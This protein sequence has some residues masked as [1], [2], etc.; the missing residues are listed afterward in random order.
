M[1]NIFNYP[2]PFTDKTYFFFEHNQPCCDLDVEIDIYSL[3]GILVATIHKTVSTVGSSI[4][5]I[6]WNG[7]NNDGAKLGSGTF[8]YHVKITTSGG[9]YIES[10]NKLIIIR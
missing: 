9:S 2:N 4:E 3:M 8:L 6:Q 7:L 10:S 5:P 1:N